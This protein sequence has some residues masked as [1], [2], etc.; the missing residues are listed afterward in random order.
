MPRRVTLTAAELAAH[1]AGKSFTAGNLGLPG[2]VSG[3]VPFDLAGQG[4]TR[5]K[6]PVHYRPAESPGRACANCV[7][8]VPGGRCTL[9]AGDIAPGAVC[10]EWEPEDATK[11]AQ[12]PHVAGLMVR[13]ADTGRVLMLQRSIDDDQDYAAG[14]WEPPGGHAEPGETLIQAATREWAEEVGHPVPHG[15]VTGSWTSGDGVYRGFVLDVPSEDVVDLENGRDQVKNPDGDRFESV[16][17]FDPVAEFRGNPSLRPEMK[18]DLPR[19]L[20]AL[21]HS[22]A[23]KRAGGSAEVLREYWTGTGHPG[24]TMFALERKIRWG[25]DDDWYRCVDEVTPYLGAEG[26]KGYCNL[27]HHEVL[28]YWP[29]QHARMEREG[30]T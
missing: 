10:D 1:Q 19:V 28:G 12:A 29:A 27:R 20:A 13:A 6:E 25:E 9:V 7:M 11:S 18:R 26:A 24:P 16:A 14:C 17:W 8:F 5:S 15:T 3:M 22:K 23:E 2:T 21:G 4:P 30:K